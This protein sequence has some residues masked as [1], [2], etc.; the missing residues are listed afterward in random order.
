MQYRVR[1]TLDE[2]YIIEADDEEDA[3]EKAWERVFA[4]GAYGSEVHENEDD[5]DPDH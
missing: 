5:D 2:D 4:E 3:T 1:L